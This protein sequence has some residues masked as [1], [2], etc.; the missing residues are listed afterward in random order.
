MAAED[1]QVRVMHRATKEGLGKAYVAGFKSAFDGGAQRI[2]QMDA[3]W[4]HDPKYLTSAR[5]WP[6]EVR[7]GHR[8]ALRQGRRRPQLEPDAQ[9]RLARRVDLRADCSQL[10]G[11]TT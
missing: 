10:S 3:D 11:S 6:R 8:L 9:G 1:S 5:W 7:P 2:V 4:S